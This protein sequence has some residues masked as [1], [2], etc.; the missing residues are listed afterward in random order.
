MLILSV[1]T[2]S[3]SMIFESFSTSVKSNNISAHV[4]GNVRLADL[5]T[6]QHGKF[7]IKLSISV[8]IDFSEATAL[9]VAL[10]ESLIDVTNSLIGKYRSKKVDYY[11]FS[12]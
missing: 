12:V 2:L 1:N 11:K 10:A 8:L 6:W 5:L 7:S 4:V 3:C 9:S